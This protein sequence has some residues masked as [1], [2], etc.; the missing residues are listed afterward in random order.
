MSEYPKLKVVAVQASPVMLDLDATVA[1]TCRFVDE[2]AANG[3]KGI[4]GSIYSR[5][6]MV[7]L[8]WKCR[9]RNEILHRF[10]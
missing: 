7:D 4:S 9:L 1:K 10:V 3:A 5:I 6:S 8:A 2:A